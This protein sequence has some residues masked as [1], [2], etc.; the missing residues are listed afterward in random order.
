MNGRGGGASRCS[1]GVW[2]GVVVG[3]QKGDRSRCTGITGVDGS[4]TSPDGRDVYSRQYVHRGLQTDVEA[5]DGGIQLGEQGSGPEK[6]RR[7]HEQRRWTRPVKVL[8]MSPLSSRDCCNQAHTS[9]LTRVKGMLKPSDL[10]NRVWE[11]KRAVIATISNDGCLLPGLACYSLEITSLHGSFL[12]VMLR[13][14]SDTGAHR[15]ILTLYCG[16]MSLSLRLA[17]N[18]SYTNRAPLWEAQHELSLPLIL[19]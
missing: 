3:G 16:S 9:D 4:R 17:G 8:A 10:S 11:L 12:Q 15:D 18:M 1:R 7:S 6:A 14:S 19:D 2:R 13:S 5:D